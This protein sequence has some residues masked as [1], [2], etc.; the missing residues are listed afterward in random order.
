MRIKIPNFIEKNPYSGLP[1]KEF[2]RF[3]EKAI[4]F[5]FSSVTAHFPVKIPNS[6]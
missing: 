5:G 1:Q 2:N 4:P 3:P 6:S